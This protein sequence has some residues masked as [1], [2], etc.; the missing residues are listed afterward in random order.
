MCLHSSLVILGVLCVLCV[1]V[2]QHC[3]QFE[4]GYHGYSG[5]IYPTVD[6]SPSDSTNLSQGSHK[7]EYHV[8]NQG[9][10]GYHH[11]QVYTLHRVIR[12]SR[13]IQ[14]VCFT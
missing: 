12:V 3:R 11:Y 2:G 7:S 5:H 4:K 8:S 6:C 9:Y 13:V 10:Q 14:E 1:H